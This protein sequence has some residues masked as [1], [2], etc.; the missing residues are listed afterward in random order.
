MS[1][2]EIKEAR[3]ALAETSV[4]TESGV[5]FLAAYRFWIVAAVWLA[6]RAYSLW[7]LTPD[8]VVASYYQMAGDWLDGFTPYAAFKVEYPPGALLLFVLPRIFTE[9][10]VA[11]GYA[12]AIG[13]L[14]ADLGIL[15]LLVRIA[16]RIPRDIVSDPV[17]RCQ[18]TRLCLIY[19]LFSAFFGHLMFQRYDLIMALLLTA[20]IYWAL[21]NNRVMVDL[22][23]ALGLWFDLTVLAWIPLLWWYG[24]VSRDESLP[25]KKYS[26]IKAFLRSLLPRAAVLAG[27]LGVLFLPFIL[28]AG[29]SLGD[30]VQFHLA[31]GIQLESTAAGILLVGAKIFGVKLAAGS[32]SQTVYLTGVAGSWAAAVSGII[33]IIVFMV[34]T[35]YLARMMRQ[36]SDAAARGYW[37]IR[38]LPAT[39]LALLATSR[40]FLPPSLLWIAPLAALF[41]HADRW[42]F[43]DIGWRLLAVNLLTLIVSFFYYS[44]LAEL[45]LLPGILLLLRNGLVIWV[46]ISLLAPETPGADRPESESPSPW[47]IRKY[48]NRIPLGILF[49]W[50]TVAAFCPVS[51]NDLWLLLREAA[52]IVANGAVAEVEQYS[53]VAFGRPY[54]AHEWLSGLVFLGIFKLGGG[55]AL[56]VFRASVM[57]AMLFLLWFSLAKKDRGF[58][59]AAPLLALA[60]YTI[61]IRVFVRPHIFTLL[62]L[63]VWV[64]ALEHWRRER[65]LRCLMLLVPLQVLWANLHGGYIFAPVLGALMTGAT[66]VLVLHPGWSTDERYAWSDVGTFAALTLAC[67]AVSLINPNGYR[68]LEFSLTIGLASDYI[69][70]VVF[71]WASPFGARYAQSYGREAAIGMGLL[72]W[73]GLALNIKRRPFLDAIIALLA[74]AMS[75]QAVRF[76]A[77]IGILGFPIAVRAWRAVADNQINRLP[78]KR[79]PL[80]E[81]SL[82]GLL[83]ASTLIYG[84]PYGETK[85]RQVGW[86]LGGRMPYQETGFI[87]EQGLEGAIFN[88]YGDGAFLIYHLYPRVRPVMDSR[89]DVYGSQ[90]Y[91]EYSFSRENPVK[92]FQYLNKYKVSLILLRKSQQ[93]LQINQYLNYLAATKLLL[94]TDRRYL[95]SYDPEL[96]PPELLQQIS[97]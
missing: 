37:L 43:S 24:W 68:L 1:K 67:L 30:I 2:S 25:S 76:L 55:E 18:Y 39:I 36:Q 78:V 96:L 42:R 81:A 28:L 15:L 3:P 20:V 92:F 65:R 88:D 49:V 64:F 32:A 95:F 66:A 11:Y 74:T 82:F 56:T 29:R 60:A 22:L 70:Q 77:F 87:S 89:I 97:Q 61:L 40:V 8:D 19:I 16:A 4:F 31:R 53:A 83:L 38:G 93:N 72:I 84:F 17:R 12:F 52:D 35:T 73:V 34:L 91:R 86:G 90:L 69:K 27:G 21:G 41:A 23:L 80:I 26:K 51:S 46:V 54:L 50:G 44:E 7:G 6:A 10:P 58:M 48:L 71:E 62:F 45:Q 13:M 94:E 75:L 79:R 14:L 47:R 57:L 33:T 63:C 9:A 85:H 5:K 59:F